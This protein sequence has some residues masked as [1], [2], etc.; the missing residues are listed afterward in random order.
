MLACGLEWLW[1]AFTTTRVYRN[2][3][4][5]LAALCQAFLQ[6]SQKTFYIVINRVRH[7]VNV[8]GVV[9]ARC[10]KTKYNTN[11]NRCN[12]EM[13]HL[14]KTVTV[15]LVWFRYAVQVYRP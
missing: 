8:L 7:A 12:I 11:K 13:L 9:K 4:L 14:Q 6:R 10:D 5:T 2:K 1:P 3:Y 15:G